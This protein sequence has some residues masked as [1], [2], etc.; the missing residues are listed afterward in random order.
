MKKVIFRGVATALVTP[1]T[2]KGVDYENLEKLINWQIEEGVQALVICGTTGECATLSDEEHR[3]VFKKSI[4][5]AGGRVAMIAGTGSNDTA[6]AIE[7]TKVAADMGYDAGLLVSPYYNKTTQAGLV[8]MY[9]A[10]ADSSPLPEIIYNVPGRTG[11]NVEPSTYAALADHPNI[12][13][14]KEANGNMEKIVET[15]ALCGDRLCMWSGED[16][17]ITPMLSVG[18]DGVISVISNILPKKTVELCQSFFD[19]DVARSAKIQLELT[20]L[21]RSLFCETNPIPVR[22]AVAAMGFGENYLRLPLVPMSK[23]KEAVM[24]QQMREQG[25]NV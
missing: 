17:I 10:I 12:V 9:K 15:M 3:E 13:G 14:I 11:M 7:L 23:D 5:F 21:I 22:A 2:E 19:G 4:E 1:M 6:Y 8:A 18:C 20:P 25:I 24:L 16:G